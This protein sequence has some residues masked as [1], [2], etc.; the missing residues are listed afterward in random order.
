MNSY[1]VIEARLGNVDPACVVMLTDYDLTLANKCKIFFH[2]APL[3]SDHRLGMINAARNSHRFW[4]VTAR[5]H[6]ST[7]G[8]LTDDHTMTLPDNMGLASNSGHVIHSQLTPLSKREFLPIDGY[9]SE[10]LNGLTGQITEALLQIDL[11]I[12]QAVG[13]QQIDAQSLQTC[14]D[15]RELC[16]AFVFQYDGT[17]EHPLYSV[18][19]NAFQQAIPARLAQQIK[20]AQKIVPNSGIH[21]QQIVQ[22]YV[23]L[24]PNGMNK[25]GFACHAFTAAQREVSRPF[26]IVAGDSAPDFEM[27][28]ALQHLPH[29]QRLFVSVGKDLANHATKEGMADLIDVA[30]IG[31]GIS[32]VE[33]FHREIVGR[34]ASPTLQSL[35]KRLGKVGGAANLPV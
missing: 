30:L 24:A 32:P 26:V 34:L 17:T 29:S 27:M 11:S 6:D 20:L 19:T 22:G 12:K 4:V 28:K 21:G 10:Q 8:Y 31:N 18:I 25:G 35:G 15:P 9:S 5:G 3:E 23:D 7:Y 2:N 14:L 16:G 13:T 33:E 1:D